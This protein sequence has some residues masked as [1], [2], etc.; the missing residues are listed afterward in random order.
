[1]EKW[2]FRVEFDGSVPNF[3]MLRP[4][5]QWFGPIYKN[6][7]VHPAELEFGEDEPVYA[8]VCDDSEGCPGRSTRVEK[9]PG[10]VLTAEPSLFGTEADRRSAGKMPFNKMNWGEWN[11]LG[12]PP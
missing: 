10:L 3:P 11:L 1:M 6:M 12:D 2:K 5:R 7:P 8:A 4:H 9:I